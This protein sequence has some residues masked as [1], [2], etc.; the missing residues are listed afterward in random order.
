MPLNAFANASYF[1]LRSGGKT[2]ITF[3]F[4]SGALWFVSVPL[5]FILFYAAG[6]P[7]RVIYP[8]VQSAEIIKVI[9][10]FILIRKRVWVRTIV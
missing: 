1:T 7:V 4:D 3:V 5:A 6:L 2:L 10:G 8:I 9:I